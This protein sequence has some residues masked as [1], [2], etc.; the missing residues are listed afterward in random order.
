MAARRVVHSTVYM[1]CFLLA[2]LLGGTAIADGFMTTGNLTSQPIGHYEF[3]KGNPFECSIRSRDRGPI[4]MS[5][6]W[7]AAIE[8]VNAAV[9]REIAPM[10]DQD[11]YG[12]EEFWAY[13]VNGVGDCEDYVLEKRRRLHALGIPLSNLLITVVRKPDGEGHAVLTVRTSE[14]DLVLD[15]LSEEIKL[16]SWTNY[17]YLKRQAVTHSGRWVSLR[18]S[19]N[20][21]V[22]AVRK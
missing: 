10:N 3:C 22:G 9:N 17:E 6:E 11:I 14:G 16:W 2:G 13:P 21:L 7:R 5:D 8:Y 1:V 12:K 15:N 19:N 20:L 4:T 18:D